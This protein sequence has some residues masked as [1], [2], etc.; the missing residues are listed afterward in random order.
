M[1]G[2]RRRP[3][4]LTALPPPPP[5]AAARARPPRSGA[6]PH[7]PT[8]PPPGSATGRC[9]VSAAPPHGPAA[10][11]KVCAAQPGGRRHGAGGA[12][13]GPR[14]AAPLRAAPRRPG[15]AATSSSSE[16]PGRAPRLA[17]AA[18]RQG[19]GQRRFP[20]AP[21]TRPEGGLLRPSARAG[22]PSRTAR[23]TPRGPSGT[24]CRG[25]AP[26]PS[27]PGPGGPCLGGFGPTPSSQTWARRSRTALLTPRA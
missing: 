5:P 17:R 6:A 21:P 15:A 23:L 2:G 3:A 10:R 26:F 13:A 14:R 11:Q 9:R 8:H 20:A 16:L 22:S 12:S 25:F 24:L 1:P 7:P 18:P 27:A 19:E 4:P